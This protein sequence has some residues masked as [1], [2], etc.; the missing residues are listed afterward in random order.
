MCTI[1]AIKGVCCE[2]EKVATGVSVKL[3]SS[4]KKL[5]ADID[6]DVDVNVSIPRPQ[7]LLGSLDPVVP[8]NSYCGLAFE[9]EFKVAHL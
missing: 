5:G 1:Y 4:K 7:Q 8:L 6:V 3:L 9:G 2:K